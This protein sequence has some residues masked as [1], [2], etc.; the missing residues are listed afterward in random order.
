[1]YSYNKVHRKQFGE[2]YLYVLNYTC[3]PSSYKENMSVMTRVVTIAGYQIS[4]D[5]V[6]GL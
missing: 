2:I 3:T 5:C 1:M 6:V 4:Q